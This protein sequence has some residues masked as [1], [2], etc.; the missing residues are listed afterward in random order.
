DTFLFLFREELISGYYDRDLFSI[1][2]R[3][4]QKPTFFIISSTALSKVY[5]KDV[6]FENIYESDI[7]VRIGDLLGNRFEIIVRN[8]ERAIVPEQIKRL[9]SPIE[10]WGGFP[11]F[12]GIQRF[13]VIRPITHLVGKHIVQSD[14]EKAA[15]MYVAHPMIGENEVTYSLREELEKTR[16]YTKAFHSYPDALNFEKAMLN[17]LIQ[18]PN[19]FIG[20]FKELP[21]NLLMMFVNAYES[22]LFNK[23]LSERIRRKIPIH[24]AIV[25]DIICPVR[26]N[27]VTNDIIPVRET[28]LDKVNKQISKKKAVVS[29]LLIG[30][31][32]VFAEGE[33]GEIEHAVIESEKIDPR[34]FIIPEIPFLSSSGSR[35]ALLALVPC[36][37]WTLH[38]DELHEENQ[39]LTLRFELQKGCYATSLLREIMKS[40]GPKN[41]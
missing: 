32:T 38:I 12:Y 33:M 24:H 16:D 1:V 27:V 9:S 34:D 37:E 18:N 21:K 15:M 6:S 10:A 14:F 30:C 25:G 8:I 13:G 41:Y 23:M 11:N 2:G 29:G 19:D 31:D 35:R 3:L 4:Y 40:N 17:K 36:L 26:K 5:I 7:P 20:A 22:V 28:N 39:A